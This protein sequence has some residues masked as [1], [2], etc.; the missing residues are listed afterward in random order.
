MNERIEKLFEMNEKGLD[1]LDEKEKNNLHQVT[2]SYINL[3]PF[4]RKI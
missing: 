4:L 2:Y 3:E 1:K